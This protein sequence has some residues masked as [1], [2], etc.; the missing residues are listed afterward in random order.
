M[1]RFSV[2]RQQPRPLPVRFP[3]KAGIFGLCLSLFVG[4]TANAFAAP[5]ENPFEVPVGEVMS[6]S[7]QLASIMRSPTR[8]CG[9]RCGSQCGSSKCGGSTPV[10]TRPAVVTPPPPPPKPVAAPTPAIEQEVERPAAPALVTTE[11]TSAPKAD[12]ASS[13][14]TPS[15]EPKHYESSQPSVATKT[16]REHTGNASAVRQGSVDRAKRH[17]GYGRVGSV[18]GETEDDETYVRDLDHNRISSQLK[19]IGGYVKQQKGN[20]V[21][22]TTTRPRKPKKPDQPVVVNP[23]PAIVEQPEEQP[24][25]T[26]PPKKDP[27]IPDDPDKELIANDDGA[28][29]AYRK[30]VRGNVKGN[31]EYEGYVSVSRLSRTQHGNMRLFSSGNWSYKNSIL[32]KNGG[33]DSFTYLLQDTEGNSDTA[34]VTI[35][36]A[37]KKKKKKKKRNGGGGKDPGGGRGGGG[38]GGGGGI[39]AN[40]RAMAEKYSKL[41]PDVIAAKFGADRAVKERYEAAGKELASGD[42]SHEKAARAQMRVETMLAQGA[43]DLTLD[44]AQTEY[45]QAVTQQRNLV[46]AVAKPP[47][48]TFKKLLQSSAASGG[49]LPVHPLL[50]A[51][52]GAPAAFLY[53][54]MQQP[55]VQK[56][57]GRF[58]ARANKIALNTP[59]PDKLKD[60]AVNLYQRVTAKTDA[61]SKIKMQKVD[62]VRKPAQKPA[63]AFLRDVEHL[64]L[65][66][67]KVQRETLDEKGLQRAIAKVSLGQPVKGKKPK[68]Q[69][70]KLNVPALG[71]P[72]LSPDDRTHAVRFMRKV[73][74]ASPLLKQLQTSSKKVGKQVAKQYVEHAAAQTFYS[75][76]VGKERLL[77]MREIAE[78]RVGQ[79]VGVGR[80]GL[81]DVKEIAVDE[82]FRVRLL[83]DLQTLDKDRLKHHAKRLSDVRAKQ[84]NATVDLIKHQ[85]SSSADLIKQDYLSARG[86]LERVSRKIG[87]G[88]MKATENLPKVK[89]ELDQVRKQ[90]VGRLDKGQDLGDLE[91]RLKTLTKAFN[92][93]DKALKKARKSQAFNQALKTYEQR[94]AAYRADL[95]KQKA[96]PAS[97]KALKE[98]ASTQKDA[99]VNAFTQRL[100]RKGGL[101][102]PVER[103]LRDPRGAIDTVKLADFQQFAQRV[104][105]MQAPLKTKA[106]LPSSDQVKRV[107]SPTRAASLR[108]FNAADL[109][110]LDG[111]IKSIEAVAAPGPVKAAPPAESRRAVYK[112]DG[113]LPDKF[114]KA[115]LSEPASLEKKLRNKIVGSNDIQRFSQPKHMR[116]IAMVQQGKTDGL[117]TQPKKLEGQAFVDA[118]NNA[119]G[120]LGWAH[121]FESEDALQ[122]FAQ[123]RI[124]GLGMA[125]KKSDLEDPEYR[126]RL[127]Q[128]RLGGLVAVHRF[129]S[130]EDMRDFVNSRLGGLGRAYTCLDLL[131]AGWS[132]DQVN[133]MFDRAREFG[134]KDFETKKDWGERMMREHGEEFTRDPNGEVRFKT[135]TEKR[136]EHEAEM[137]ASGNFI[138][139]PQTGN[140][141]HKD[142]KAGRQVKRK[143]LAAKPKKVKIKLAGGKEATLTI[144]GFTSLNDALADALRAKGYV[145]NAAG[146]WVDGN[147]NIVITGGAARHYDDLYTNAMEKQFDGFSSV[148]TRRPPPPPPAVSTTEESLQALTDKVA[149]SVGY[150][151]SN[152]EIGGRKIDIE[153][154]PGETFSD[155]LRR[156]IGDSSRYDFDVDGNLID[157]ENDRVVLSDEEITKKDER[158][159]DRVLES[160]FGEDQ[161]G[162]NENV[163]WMARFGTPEQKRT[164]QAIIDQLDR[165]AAAVTASVKAQDEIK[166]KLAELE[167]DDKLS[168]QE[169]RRQRQILQAQ[170]TTANQ[171]RRDAETVLFNQANTA[172]AS[173]TR[174]QERSLT[175]DERRALA[176]YDDL[177][178]VRDDIAALDAE[179]AKNPRQTR[180]KQLLAERA[181]KLKQL[182]GINQDLIEQSSELIQPERLAG[183]IP[184]ID[185]LRQTFDPSTAADWRDARD[186]AIG[187]RFEERD[188]KRVAVYIGPD[189][190]PFVDPG[191][192]GPD[193]KPK[194]IVVS[195]SAGEKFLASRKNRLGKERDYF[196]RNIGS[197]EDA[198][199]DL[200]KTNTEVEKLEAKA[201]K[202]GLKGWE[203]TKLRKLKRKQAE[204]QAE[205][206]EIKDRIDSRTQSYRQVKALVDAEKAKGEGGEKSALGEL[207][208]AADQ[209]AAEIMVAREKAKEE[210]D[211]GIRTITYTDENGVERTWMSEKGRQYQAEQA[212]K[213]QEAAERAV[214]EAAKAA[215]KAVEEAA[216]EAERIVREERER[217]IALAKQIKA[218]RDAQASRF[219]DQFHR[220]EDDLK[221]A[222]RQ[223]ASAQAELDAAARDIER[224]RAG[225]IE[226]TPE[227]K[228]RYADAQKA[229]AKAN[230]EVE[231]KRLLANQAEALAA[232]NDPA[233]IALLNDEQKKIRTLH[234]S[235]TDAQ[236]QTS[237][238]FKALA[239]L[240]NDPK[241]SAEDIRQAREAFAQA[242]KAE[243]EARQ[244]VIDQQT[245]MSAM[246][247]NALYTKATPE[248][249]RARIAQLEER[250]GDKGTQKGLTKEENEEYWRRRYLQ[251]YFDKVAEAQL[252]AQAIQEM[253]AAYDANQQAGGKYRTLS[254]TLADV[255]RQKGYTL[256]DEGK[257][258]DG[259][260][261]VVMRDSTSLSQ[262]EMVIL[263]GERQRQ[264][265]LKELGGYKDQTLAAQE[266]QLIGEWM[267][268]M[269]GGR[270]G[271]SLLH[272]DQDGSLRRELL[273]FLDGREAAKKKLDDAQALV[274]QRQQELAQARAAAAEDPSAY[275][276]R[277]IDYSA[278]LLRLAE[279]RVRYARDQ[280]KSAEDDAKE[281]DEALSGNAL[282]AH[283]TGRVQGASTLV[284]E[285]TVKMQEALVAYQLNPTAAN[286]RTFEGR[287][288]DLNRAVGLLNEAEK[289]VRAL[290]GRDA[291]PGG[292]I[293]AVSYLDI[294]RSDR[295]IEQ[296]ALVARRQA[297]EERYRAARQ[298]EFEGL[299]KV[300]QLRQARDMSQED[301]NKAVAA[302]EKQGIALQAERAKAVKAGDRNKIAL[303]DR[304]IADQQVFHEALDNTLREKLADRNMSRERLKLATLRVARDKADEAGDSDKVKALDKQIKDQQIVATYHENYAMRVRHRIG[305]RSFIEAQDKLVPKEWELS[306]E[307]AAREREYRFQQALDIQRR[308]HSQNQQRAA[309]EG[310]IRKDIKVLEDELLALQLSDKRGSNKADIA[311]KE[312]ELSDARAAF[313]NR[314]RLFDNGDRN[315][316]EEWETLV[317]QNRRDGIGPTSDH[318][319]HKIAHQHNINLNAVFLADA[320]VVERQRKGGSALVQLYQDQ[321]MTAERD[322]WGDYFLDEFN[323]LN[324]DS[325]LRKSANLPWLGKTLAGNAV[326]VGKG[327]YKTVEGI[328]KLVPAV[329]DATYESVGIL[330]GADIETDTLDSINR[331]LDVVDKRGVGRIVSDMKNDFFK[332]LNKGDAHWNASVAGGE[333]AFEVVAAVLTGGES[334]LVRGSSALG[335]GAEF[336][337]RTARVLDKA[338]DLARRGG[339][340]AQTAQRWSKASNY[341]ADGM[342]T[343]AG[344]TV[345]LDSGIRSVARRGVGAVVDVIEAPV[346]ALTR[347][348]PDALKPDIL[349]SLQRGLARASVQE[350]Q[351]AQRMAGALGRAENLLA[352][353]ARSNDTAEIAKL[354]DEAMGLKKTA[355]VFFEKNPAAFDLLADS[356]SLSRS[357]AGLNPSRA[358]TAFVKAADKAESAG[359]A[360]AAAAFRKSAI[361]ASFASEFGHDASQQLRRAAQDS[362]DQRLLNSLDDFAPAV[363]ADPNQIARNLRNAFQADGVSD[364]GLRTKADDL[365]Q[366]ATQDRSLLQQDIAKL[367]RSL[368]GA[369]AEAREAGARALAGKQEQLAKLNQLEKVMTNLR[370]APEVPDTALARAVPDQPTKP[371]SFDG[372]DQPTVTS[373]SGPTVAGQAARA[374][375]KVDVPAEKLT[376]DLV[377]LDPPP[378]V[379]PRKPDAP[380]LAAERQANELADVA[381]KAP[382]RAPP[383][384]PDKPPVASSA[385][386]PHNLVF[387]TTQGDTVELPLGDYLGKG[388]FSKAHKAGHDPDNLVVRMTD[389]DKNPEAR[390]LDEFGRK[391]LEEQVD[392]GVVR[393]VRREARFEVA[394]SPDPALANRRGVELV[395]R[396]PPP[397]KELFK[398]N[399]DGL[400]SP[401]QAKA[402]DRAVKEFNDKGLVWGD[403][404]HDNYTFEALDGDDNWRVVVIDPGGIV[405]IKPS[406]GRTAAQNARDVQA[407]INAPMPEEFA[408]L[409][410]LSRGYRG[411]VMKADIVENFGELID[412]KAVGLK[413]LD[414]VRF[415]PAGVLDYPKA[416]ELFNLPDDQVAKRVAK[417]Q[418]DREAAGLVPAKPDEVLQATQLAKDN[419]VRARRA[420]DQ[421]PGGKVD[422]DALAAAHKQLDEL[423]GPRRDTASADDIAKARSAYDDLSS[424][425][426]E[427][428][429][430]KDFADDIELRQSL[431]G[432]V[433]KDEQAL[434]RLTRS[435]LDWLS[436]KRTRLTPDEE[437]WA[438]KMIDAVDGDWAKLTKKI[439]DGISEL[440]MH[441]LVSYRRQ[442][443]DRMLDAAIAKVER[444]T[445][446]KLTRQAFGSTNLTSDYDLSVTG[447]GAERVVAEFNQA[448]RNRF[449]KEPGSFFDTNVYTDPVYNLYSRKALRD[450]GLD[451]PPTEV[452]EFRQFMFDQM[453]NRKYLN[454]QQWVQHVKILESSAP[455]ESTR[456]M[457]R[458][459]L[460]RVD[461]AEQTARKG[462]QQRM[463]EVSRRTGQDI[464]DKN[465]EFQAKNEL[466]EE[467]L[468]SIDAFRQ[469]HDFLTRLSA[470]RPDIDMPASGVRS[471]FTKADGTPMETA[472]SRAVDEMRKL[473]KSG[474]PKKIAKAD[475]LKAEWQGRLENQMRNR[476]GT[477]L[478]YAS[479]AYQTQGTIAHVVR[480]IQAGDKDISFASLTAKGKK[481]A[482]D[483]AVSGYLNSF[484]ENRA[485]MFKELNELRSGDGF[486]SY[487][488]KAAGKAA[489]YF[490]R[491]LDAAHEAGVDLTAFLPDR[492]IKATVAANANRSSKAALKQALKDL[493]FDDPADFVRQAESA[494]HMLLREGMKRSPL[495][496]LA[497]AVDAHQR[498]VNALMR[499]V[500]AVDPANIRTV[501]RKYASEAIPDENP[502]LTGNARTA[503]DLDSRKSEMLAQR[504]REQA[505]RLEKGGETPERVAIYRELAKEADERATSLRAADYQRTLS[506]DNNSGMRERIVGGPVDDRALRRQLTEAQRDGAPKEQLAALQAEIDSTA[507]RRAEVAELL[508]QTPD[509]ELMAKR[510]PTDDADLAARMSEFREW[511]FEQV[512]RRWPNTVRTGTS[513]KMGNDL[514]FSVSGPNAGRD[515]LAIEKFLREEIEIA[516][517]IKGLGK[518]WD[519]KLHSTAFG[520]PELIHIYDRLPEPK[521]RARV[522]DSLAEMVEAAQFERLK[523]SMSPESWET[524]KRSLPD[525]DVEA[526]IAQHQLPA[527]FD[528]AKLLLA[529]DQAYQRLVKSGF[530]DADAAREVSRTQVM[531]N[532]NDPEAYLSFGGVKQTVTFK[533][534]LVKFDRP[535]RARIENGNVVID[536]DAAATKP[537]LV[538]EL[539]G[540]R[541]ATRVFENVADLRKYLNELKAQQ[542]GIRRLSDQ[543][544]VQRTLNEL[545]NTVLRVEPS[546][547]YQSVLGNMAFF[548]HQIELVGG[549]PLLAL[550]RYQT[551]KYLDRILSEAYEMGIPAHATGFLGEAKS[552]ARR[553]Y[554]ERDP[555]IARFF[556]SETSNLDAEAY[557]ALQSQAKDLLG[558]LRQLNNSIAARARDD[559]LKAIRYAEGPTIIPE[560]DDPARVASLVLGGDGAV[561]AKAYRNAREALGGKIDGLAIDLSS[562][563][564][565]GLVLP[566]QL[567]SVDDADEFVGL[568]AKLDAETRASLGAN[569]QRLYDLRFDDSIRPQTLRIV[570]RETDPNIL[571]ALRQRSFDEDRVLLE[572][573]TPDGKLIP[574]ASTGRPFPQPPAGGGVERFGKDLPRAPKW[575]AEPPDVAAVEGRAALPESDR[576]KRGAA[577]Q[578][579]SSIRADAR[580]RLT[581]TL[582]VV[583]RGQ[584]SVA[585]IRQ[586]RQ[587]LRLNDYQQELDAMLVAARN[588]GVSEAEI[589]AAVGTEAAYR[590]APFTARK[591]AIRGLQERL[592]QRAG[593]L[594]SDD[595]I[596]QLRPVLLRVANGVS[597]R[598][599]DGLVRDWIT[600]F[601]RQDQNFI[602]ELTRRGRIDF[603]QGFEP[604]VG[605]ETAARLL[606][607]AEAKNLIS[608]SETPVLWHNP[609]RLAKPTRGQGTPPQFFN[610]T[611]GL[612]AVEGAMRDR[613]LITNLRPESGLR[614][615]A[616][617][618]KLF[619][620]G[621]GMTKA[622]LSQWIGREGGDVNWAGRKP[623]PEEMLRQLDDD[624]DL[625]VMIRTGN[626]AYHWVRVENFRHSPVDGQLWVAVGDPANGKSWSTPA[627]LLA[628][629]IHGD[630]VL[631]IDWRRAKG[632]IADDVPGRGIK[633]SRAK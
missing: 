159:R 82:Q 186:R 539:P 580:T 481:A 81:K 53:R 37:P 537:G 370:D 554:K 214:E 616:L 98:K 278:E 550:R 493:G 191:E 619:E 521:L 18:D 257:W 368:Q 261:R 252:K 275:S 3:G 134:A 147:G 135:L 313:S 251:D 296:Q 511:T 568:P 577:L 500:G 208:A 209:E 10:F 427:A 510:M 596:K 244:K 302:S 535:M 153:V 152:V 255:M 74:K 492:L 518:H 424:R 176:L 530:K 50:E 148:V 34:T 72:R 166:K 432:K 355:A 312:Q 410:K 463:S 210:W 540:Q 362:I 7:P 66:S 279:G 307:Y 561:V 23:G 94:R 308:M 30:R 421:P 105:A 373:P 472:Y 5:S 221:S 177:Q 196:N 316:R 461:D 288:D 174:A 453:A 8:R 156:V 583:E 392:Q 140:L 529:R 20:N 33:T 294:L 286:R 595:N 446:R 449:K 150:T 277:Q 206:R 58:A 236:S 365:I 484:N 474:D 321:Q 248:F 326:G 498:E 483:D 124:G 11:T 169:K 24:G 353:A 57:V 226:N 406:P 145:Q 28:S 61:V 295:K 16:E 331:V 104:P 194:E 4:L 519:R 305:P 113:D 223:Q 524:F 356:G 306:A 479:E 591:A 489:K 329:A 144:D 407:R 52:D 621:R 419:L 304:Q 528:R 309:S 473:Y 219:R 411:D 631:S 630:N 450:R 289:G 390:Q 590:L 79:V 38:S 75:E 409:S 335:R 601:A 91:T 237:A 187:V 435:D 303:L 71:E 215:Q 95:K 216:Q 283:R 117:K 42:P 342:R 143:I 376:D 413:S 620:P 388:S 205:V 171:A 102:N 17:L 138:R 230:A 574:A 228:K 280:L 229:L 319:V 258:L 121:E 408:T 162:L 536:T 203:Q 394:S 26:P 130:M 200:Q 564:R 508:D 118:Y 27:V 605:E 495:N 501:S 383:E 426:I 542:P 340:I 127:L 272:P 323:P 557:A 168:D 480:E 471:Q 517:G 490:I 380:L 442:E 344:R 9:S 594:V 32:F 412:Y 462:L 349:P 372:P 378:A 381:D 618:S 448:F 108:T 39:P 271:K 41:P 77:A 146:D 516:P 149:A 141:V 188:G 119:V 604:I 460:Q 120:N 297:E 623:T 400:M 70:V 468:K 259:S 222:E 464:G 348:V 96:D 14:H 212:K 129:D 217:Q 420:A 526:R 588:S 99:L 560:A 167:T 475:K 391:V 404:K 55:G 513:G 202:E 458:E 512:Q 626:D 84:A 2:P 544:V 459:T 548:E 112:T 341:V 578:Q 195:A 318:D 51:K 225:K 425:A 389:I 514:D 47:V 525:V 346:G 325:T 593:R 397:A 612:M 503:V 398:R 477:A 265:K 625:I 556:G 629:Q 110:T 170:L 567:R 337:S 227:L 439:G 100:A 499:S 97:A 242:S 547:R 109:S 505:S 455:D 240:K 581:D 224:A 613:N 76:V 385:D 444:E 387:T 199:K 440:E 233:F 434:Q 441:K 597:S 137:L 213:A 438:Q 122:R 541:S 436:G 488:D 486:G 584:A 189:G 320:N 107:D 566:A 12:T 633:I 469:D 22:G 218:Q 589:A 132:E 1:I 587:A 507:L 445:G 454:D 87:P 62:V 617:K 15:G 350:V 264:D 116:D 88:V 59:L 399:H 281:Q 290:T 239:A 40:C 336:V 628:A 607:Q 273:G 103:V 467:S 422:A 351:N 220:Y 632:K 184:D 360:I 369:N 125:H 235:Y 154:R 345:A 245:A 136:Q 165:Q 106:V 83:E 86:Q 197:L 276:R 334:V 465:V 405:P 565:E 266:M 254:E 78:G 332:K 310:Q 314:S 549:D 322:T 246:V 142:T 423:Q 315:L 538:L 551:S 232:S 403:N 327:A 285:R 207:L 371:V 29:T 563:R 247:D 379:P 299:Q 496:R 377:N 533:E 382:A 569:S 268:S 395:E 92:D 367:E 317:T 354:V 198:W 433:A 291:T 161:K 123:E 139:D 270:G 552:L 502:L 311:V 44:I 211:K 361:T 151:V 608:S 457:I 56:Q 48:D 155:A 126:A 172:N 520:D 234:Q 610:D 31:D 163:L 157:L 21:G 185:T 437:A 65:A 128:E 43:D 80:D 402:F 46:D 414:E 386:E 562:H 532:R 602:E 256:N 49:A 598:A 269:R 69:I 534:G 192:L 417:W 576:S 366:K 301:L 287:Q 527:D 545:E 599:D 611:C 158:Y 267:T 131:D 204:Q 416:R 624:K 531:L 482:D 243:S 546:E 13:V 476:Q 54:K 443:V 67:L 558:Q 609:V 115:S 114:T 293:P 415:N 470:E 343:L 238:K 260:G 284:A 274:L 582:A 181:R 600:R 231:Q 487:A 570:T 250:A 575:N 68:P 253:Q 6:T 173:A 429:A 90:V 347:K 592:L 73:A 175:R 553:F 491:Q 93:G 606:K 375:D 603:E 456:R 60:Q 263:V 292:G 201:A 396:A 19:N 579:E 262:E 160:I 586:Y 401:G 571:Q 393:I 241:A 333:V 430:R 506:Q 339:Q 180:R 559:A 447:W 133:G 164:A 523:H 543:L 63:T 359:D 249:N 478:Y 324:A 428:K 485:N 89:R 300:E 509:W 418:A 352:R 555:T 572:F 357:V 374:A 190:K 298:R 622:Q 451:L 522:R 182:Y 497:G 363:G 179:L 627:R 384:A 338:G 452:D 515:Q 364:R 358:S 64:R 45:R 330:A 35:D 85:F 193:G 614:D 36:I 25:L 431:L 328:V 178:D 282:L 615:I 101:E 111:R 504:L 573:R 494:S 466:Y 585:Q 183:R